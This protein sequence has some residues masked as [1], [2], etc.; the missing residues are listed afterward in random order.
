[1]FFMMWFLTIPCILMATYILS[2]RT[3][4][5]EQGHYNNWFWEV[6]LGLLSGFH[7]FLCVMATYILGTRFVG[8]ETLVADF[9]KQCVLLY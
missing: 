1:M 8:L 5:V 4:A 2:A 7:G 6:V 9:E 3:L